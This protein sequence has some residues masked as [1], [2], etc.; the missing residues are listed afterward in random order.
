MCG[1]FCLF[2]SEKCCEKNN[3]LQS[4]KS[5]F[6]SSILERGPDC[7]SELEFNLEGWNAY[8][9]A[10]VLG[11]QGAEI[12][13]Q[14]ATDEE[15]NLLLWNGD[16]FGGPTIPP[17]TSDTTF[18]S[19]SL[20]STQGSQ[21]DI[22]NILSSVE[23]PW[24]FVYWNR[25]T[26]ELWFG[27]DPL[28]RHSL[29]WNAKC[30]SNLVLSSIGHRLTEF[31]EV[32][33]IGIFLAKFSEEAY[34]VTLFPWHNLDI[35]CAIENFQLNKIFNFEVSPDIMAKSNYCSNSLLLPESCDSFIQLVK[36]GADEQ[37]ET[38][39][40]ES[41][42]EKLLSDPEV[43]ARVDNLILELKTAVD[44]RCKLQPAKCKSCK[45]AAEALACR[46]SRVAVLF[47]GGLD[48]TIIAL[49]AHF[50]VPPGSSIDLIN[51]AFPCSQ[52]QVPRTKGKKK[53]S[54][55]AEEPAIV[56]TM[57]Q[58]LI[59]S[60][61]SYETPDRITGKASFSELVKIAPDREF[62]F[63]EVN[64]TKDELKLKRNECIADLIFPL[65][66]ILDDSLGCALWFAARGQGIKHNTAGTTEKG[67]ESPANVLL[68][69]MGADELLGG[70]SKYRKQFSKN[71][72]WSSVAKLLAHD[73]AVIPYRN[74][75]RDDRVVSNSGRQPR[76]P[77]LAENFVQFIVNLPAHLRTAP[78][79]FLPSGA[80]EKLLLRLAAFR[81]GLK[82]AST[83]P[84][85]A[86]QFGSKIANL[87]CKNEI[88]HNVCSRLLLS[89]DN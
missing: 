79:G 23:G 5:H 30:S 17:A 21:K 61:P 22:V 36:D 38:F 58:Q 11:L 71:E 9:F 10:S 53:G 44:V 66:S 84:K 52:A 40:I 62:N 19:Q 46:H 7:S 6:K 26:K 70:Y 24:S 49:L 33:A 37:A 41:F 12:T 82:V 87:E 75:G 25:A 56:D 15:G 1:I 72:D 67:Y 31:E 59:Q 28:G 85:R 29:L 81:L 43:L 47:S 20:Q 83:A 77:F 63:V 57:E 55:F 48:S 16:V 3:K 73:L 13:S 78:F 14:P 60:D 2:S 4:L 42:Y 39:N 18:L 69:G 27:R 32:P 68:L 45:N 86:L 64:V 74:L 80:G 35:N 50:C 51:V 88:G 65:N 76:F 8:F 89:E 34:S 54:K